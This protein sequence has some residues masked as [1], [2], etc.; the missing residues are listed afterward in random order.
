M[1]RKS[2]KCD[3][4]REELYR[5]EATLS[6]LCKAEW[7]RAHIREAINKWSAQFGVPV[8]TI[9]FKRLDGW[10]GVCHADPDRIELATDRRGGRSPLTAAHEF[11]HHV[12]NQRD[13]DSEKAP[14]GPEFVAILGTILDMEGIVP[15][16][17]WIETCAKY[18]VKGA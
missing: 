6:G 14:H 15:R 10:H 11:A 13:P 3:P 9:V 18:G 2:P 7:S 4:Q 1:S 16:A 8:P 12:L 5:A 17:G